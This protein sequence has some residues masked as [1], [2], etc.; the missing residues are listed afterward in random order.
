E[1]VAKGHPLLRHLD[2]ESLAFAGAK[3]LEAPEGSVVLAASENG[4][5]LIYK[6]QQP[7]R[8]AVVFNLDPAQGDFF[9]SPWFPVMVYDAARDLVGRKDAL[10]AVYATGTKEPGVP[11]LYDSDDGSYG[12]ALLESDETLIDREVVSAENPQVARGQL[13]GWWLLVVALVVL[14]VE[15]MLYH[16]RKLG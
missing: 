1:E 14:A 4:V 10:R 8:T 12:I 11:G 6:L 15:S 5:P 16:R 13:L 9:L 3:K 7:G 2:I